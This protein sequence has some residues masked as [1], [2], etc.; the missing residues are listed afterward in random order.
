MKI[1]NIIQEIGYSQVQSKRV[2]TNGEQQVNL[3][4]LEKGCEIPGHTSTK[5][6]TIVILEGKLLFKIHGKNHELETLD[7]YSFGAN[8]THA[9]TAI[10]D[11]KIL[12]VQ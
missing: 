2:V 6:A 1:K 3:I 11:T 7:T 4:S 5:D 8:E 10:E 12:L 9:L